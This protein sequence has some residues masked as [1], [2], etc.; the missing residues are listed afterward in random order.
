MTS[1]SKISQKLPPKHYA[2]PYIK[3][4]NYK[5]FDFSYTPK[6]LYPSKSQFMT[7]NSPRSNKPFLRPTRHSSLNFEKREKYISHSNSYLL[8]KIKR[9]NKNEDH[10]LQIIS[11][12]LP[13][14]ND[15]Y[16]KD[17]F[18]IEKSPIGN[19]SLWNSIISKKSPSPLILRF[20]R[21]ESK[22]YKEPINNFSEENSFE[23]KNKEDKQKNENNNFVE[24]D[25]KVSF[26]SS[27]KIQIQFIF[28]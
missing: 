4:K 24:M 23:E 15:L 21:V 13:C 20:T 18:P 10:N 28:I 19:L 16:E 3:T 12:I 2:S 25:E 7:P 1:S 5:V 6:E 22:C 11:R 14:E 8:K 9:I 27:S 26:A 17:D